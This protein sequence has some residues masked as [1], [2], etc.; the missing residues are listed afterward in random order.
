MVKIGDF[1]LARDVYK[2]SYYRKS[3]GE[4]PV[5]WMAPECLV[6][7]VYTA[8]VRKKELSYSVSQQFLIFFPQERLLGVRRGYVGGLDA[9]P[10]AVPWAAG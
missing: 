8:Q 2:N 3:G 5:R 10:A 4:V 7:G 6:D 1:G 9:G